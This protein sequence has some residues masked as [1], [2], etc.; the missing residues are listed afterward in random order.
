MNP[1]F[2][3][4]WDDDRRGLDSE[5]V[6]LHVNKALLISSSPSL[7]PRDFDFVSDLVTFNTVGLNRRSSFDIVQPPRHQLLS[8]RMEASVSDR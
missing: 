2:A 1:L 8:D 3:A 4:Y 7:I 5:L 6:V